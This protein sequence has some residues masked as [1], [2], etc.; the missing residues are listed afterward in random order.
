MKPIITVDFDGALLQHRPFQ[1]AH[2]DW[3][4][5]MATLLEDPSINEY[6]EIDDYFPKVH[7]VMKK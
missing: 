4:K 7:E 5:V 3:F 1:Q 2:K 6:A